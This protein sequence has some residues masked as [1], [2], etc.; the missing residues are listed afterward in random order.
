MKK[1]GIAFLLVSFFLVWP[2]HAAKKEMQ[3]IIDMFEDLQK[4]IFEMKKQ[5]DK[6]SLDIKSIEDFLN[7]QTLQT[8]KTLADITQ[9]LSG[10]TTD[11]QSISEKLEAALSKLNTLSTNLS[12]SQEYR[13]VEA[14][15]TQP[16][17]TGATGLQ[18]DTLYR[19]AYSDYVSGS[20]DL[21]IAGFKDY[22]NAYP[23]S[24]L[25]DDAQY[26][27]GECY[28]AQKNYKQ[29]LENFS[30]VIAAFPNGDRIRDAELKKAYCLIEMNQVA[31]GILQ[32]Q[33]VIQVYP[34]SQQAFKAREKLQELGMQKQ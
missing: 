10:L 30:K 28:Y 32:L 15:Q 24:D 11:V 29:A 9:Q 27:I 16:V 12:F 3:Q 23:N 6:N 5:L 14:G 1:I 22:L 25:S 26:W 19:T 8:G 2:S 21:A 4:Q 7:N 34:N 13:G 17:P 33:H 18:P 20:Y 31:Q